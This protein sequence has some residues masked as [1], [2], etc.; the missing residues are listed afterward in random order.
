MKDAAVALVLSSR[1]KEES[2]SSRILFTEANALGSN[3]IECRRAQYESDREY[4]LPNESAP[5]KTVFRHGRYDSSNAL[6]LAKLFFAKWIVSSATQ[7]S[8]ARAV[9]FM[10]AFS[11]TTRERRA[12]RNARRSDAYTQ[13]F[14]PITTECRRSRNCALTVNT[15]FRASS[16]IVRLSRL[17]RHDTSNNVDISCMLSAVT[18]RLRTV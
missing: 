10:K 9:A 4:A 16:W 18:L 6:R 5:K 11:P 13:A 8:I 12:G 1:A 14:F 15:L 2:D 7:F 3:W 17:P